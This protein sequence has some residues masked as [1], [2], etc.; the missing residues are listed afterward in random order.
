MQKR[1]AYFQNY[2]LFDL[3][4]S[5]LKLNTITTS[6]SNSTNLTFYMDR[7][8]CNLITNYCSI[9]IEWIQVENNTI[10]N[11]FAAQIQYWPHHTKQNYLQYYQQLAQLLVIA[12]LTSI[13]IHNL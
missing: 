11:S 10:T 13:Q 7:S 3:N 8:V 6:N 1:D 5:S 2:T 9:G 4:S 12:K